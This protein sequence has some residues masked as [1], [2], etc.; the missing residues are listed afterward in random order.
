MDDCI[1]CKIAK[2]EIPSTKLYEDENVIAFKDIEPIAPV[3]DLV[4]P[5]T[6]C[7]SLNEFDDKDMLYSIFN[8]VKEVAKIEGISEEGYRVINNVGE[9]GGQAVKHIHFHVI[10]G[11]KLP[12]RFNECDK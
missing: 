5:K 8:A 10:G 6:H 9:N 2:G 12:T 1:F 4:I 7:N 11:R 3:H